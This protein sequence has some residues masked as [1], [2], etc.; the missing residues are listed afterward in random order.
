METDDQVAALM[1]LADALEEAME[2]FEKA[3]MKLDGARTIV[4]ET[5]ESVEEAAMSA[6]MAH[7]C[8]EDIDAF[9]EEIEK[10]IEAA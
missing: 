9:V 7:D 5:H 4:E 10:L 1:E 8:K 2:T 3:R 6:D